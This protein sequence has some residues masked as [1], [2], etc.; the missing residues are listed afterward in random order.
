M[1]SRIAECITIAERMNKAIMLSGRSSVVAISTISRY[2]LFGGTL[3]GRTSVVAASSTSRHGLLGGIR[4][5]KSPAYR[6]MMAKKSRGIVR[7]SP[8]LLDAKTMPNGM[9][10]MD[11]ESLVSLA[12]MNNLDATVEVLKRHIMSIDDCSYETASKRF[13]EIQKS[14]HK[15]MWLAVSPYLAGIGI[16]TGSA[17]ASLPLCFYLPAVETFNADY[18][19]ADVPEQKDLE[20]WL[21]VGSWACKYSLCCSCGHCQFPS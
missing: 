6:R 9:S 1:H 15:G 5:L 8:T 21:E 2:G 19:T 14:N 11:N 12:A 10:E 17:I 7:F 13:D 3:S 18:V 16:A 4:T 20:T